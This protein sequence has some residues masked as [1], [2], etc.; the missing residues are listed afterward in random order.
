[1]FTGIYLPAVCERARR[2]GN[3]ADKAEA[4]RLAQ[5][6]LLAA[7]VSDV[8]GFIARGIGTEGRCHYPLGSEDQTLPWFYGLHAYVLSGLPDEEERLQ[9]VSKMRE[10]AEALEKTNWQCPCDGDFK[11]E[12]RGD[13][14]NGAPFRGAA[15]YLFILRAMVDVT[16]DEKWMRYYRTERDGIFCGTGKSRLDLCAEG[17]VADLDYICHI[18]PNLL[19]IYVGA[20]GSLAQLAKMETDPRALASY[21]SGLARNA[22]RVLPYIDAYREF[23]N[24]VVD[25]F[26]YSRWREGY[27]W[28]LQKTQRDA[29]RVAASEKREILGDRKS[30]ERRRVTNPLSAAVIAALAGGVDGRDAIKRVISHYD[31]SKINLCEFFLAE[32]AYYALPVDEQEAMNKK[33]N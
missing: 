18:E 15:H 10:V 5:G 2:S 25:P 4:G 33:K 22:A 14:K 21:R 3:A 6:L 31:Y 13:F 9:V 24:T 29:A 19:W 11:G 12:F 28:E 16:G 20:Q 17:Y 1:M 32:C 8:P 7:S 30:Y 27:V 23:D 26:A